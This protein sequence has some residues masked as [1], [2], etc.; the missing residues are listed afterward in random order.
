M[1]RFRGHAPGFT[2][3]EL[4]VVIAI[5]AVLIALL[6]PAVQ[7]VREAAA[8]MQCQSNLK[9]LAIAVHSFHDTHRRT[10]YNGR[11]IPT[12]SADQGCCGAG[13]TFWS[14][15]ARMLPF[16]EQQGLY[17]KGNVDTPTL[18]A[19]GILDATIPMLFCPTDKAINERVSTNRAD[20]GGLTVGL[21]NYKGVSG[22]N[23]GDGDA[24]WRYPAGNSTSHDGIYYGNGMFYRSDTRVQLRLNHI[25]DGTSNTFMIG[26]DIPEKTLWCSW[27][28]SN[29]AVGTCGIGPNATNPSGAEYAPGDWPNNYSFRSRHFGG[30]NFA[31][32]DGSVRFIS[33]SITLQLYRDLAS[34]KGGELASAP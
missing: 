14:W 29:N 2:L 33:N 31:L 7:K 6:L 3:I 22:S 10:P 12:A 16:I 9:Q 21:T 28:Y 5:I 25:T 18:A 8:R 23:W 30:L 26:E 17:A 15:I 32:A 24:Q 13:D 27:P 20:M 34:I 1:T 4:L 11:T 19:S